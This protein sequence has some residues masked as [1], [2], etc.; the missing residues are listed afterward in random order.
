MEHDLVDV[1]DP[2]ARTLAAVLDEVVRRRP[3]DRRFSD[4]VDICSVLVGEV[5][6]GARPHEDVTLAPGDVVELLP[7]FA[8]G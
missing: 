4:V 6:V 3:G 8:G 5:P 2:A 7:P 1:S